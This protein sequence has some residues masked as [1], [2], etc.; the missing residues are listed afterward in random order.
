MPAPGTPAPGSSDPT[1]EDR[2]PEFPGA[3]HDP[4]AAFR[5]A[6]YRRYALGWLIVLIGTQVQS[7]A[8]QWE[9]YVRTEAAISLGLV[10]LVQIVP[11][12]VF[13]LPAGHVADAY[14]RRRVI[15][16]GM[17]G[18]TLTSL[19][20][21]WASIRAVDVWMLYVLLFFD[22]T[23]LA[24]A[25]PSRSAMLPLIVPEA[26]FGNAVAWNS[27]LSQVGMVCG[28]ALGGLIVAWYP[29]AAYFLSAAAS[30]LFGVAALR[31]TAA[32]PRREREPMSLARLFG[33]AKFV[34]NSPLVLSAIALDM[35][36]VLLGGA[37]YLLPIYARDIL[38]VGEWGFG[39]LRAAPAVGAFVT[40]LALAHA[41]PM[42]RAGRNLLLGVAGFGAA[43]IV[44]GLSEWFWLSLVMLALT[45]ATDTVSVVVRHTLVQLA[46]P[47]AMR[48]RVSA[49]NSVFIGTSNEIGGFRAGSVA[50][51][52]GPVASVVLGG[53]GTLGVVAWTA[54]AAPSLRRLRRLDQVRPPEGAGE[55]GAGQRA[56]SRA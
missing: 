56:G 40:A 54:L 52:I 1:P 30:T 8:L 3:R 11:A 33:G 25:R 36:A 44:F 55:Q 34:W 20:L 5:I 45:G 23:F 53:V 51:L 22:A 6:D 21:G 42:Q 41:P 32:P 14:D 13:L 4:Y 39:L 12:L 26:I 43:T 29:P 18:T 46:T 27:S 28:P 37:T 17:A 10:G 2:P 7:V 35:F 15:T 24:L 9:I 16:L 19:A 38:H 50:E 31:I 47:D 49:V 48:G